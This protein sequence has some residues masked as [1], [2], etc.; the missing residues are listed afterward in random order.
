MRIHKCTARGERVL[1]YEGEVLERDET[2]LVVRAPWT[3][4]EHRLPYVVLQPGDVFIETFYRDHWHNIFEVR[5]ADGALKGWYANLTYPARMTKD[6]VEW[7]DLALDAWM[8]AEG[9]LAMLDGDEFAAAQG[10]LPT[11]LAAAARAAVEPMLAD[12][13]ARWIAH[14]NDQVAEKLTRRR[15]KLATAESCTGGQIGD[16][17]THRSGSSAYFIGGVIAYSNAVKQAALGV[18]T[19][20]LL[21]FGAVSEACALEMA[22]GVRRLLGAEVGV[23]ATGIAGP[24]GGSAEKPVGL[25]FVAVVTPEH[26]AVARNVWEADRLGNK[27]R[28]ADEALRLLLSALAD[29]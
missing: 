22:E 24:S 26:A 11:D 9:R 17:I 18:S 27:Q 10:T 20:T 14:A 21:Q 4:G 2:R 25:T 8:S 23:S 28:T 3:L 19:D 15:W 5:A 1:S 7:L 13:R 12:L 16:L 29:Q 6:E